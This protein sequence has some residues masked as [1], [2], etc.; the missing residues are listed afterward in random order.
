MRR[1]LIAAAALAALSGVAAAERTPSTDP[2]VADDRPFV[3]GAA[4]HERAKYFLDT[5]PEEEPKKSAVKEARALGRPT[6]SLSRDERELVAQALF[7]TGY[8]AA[9]PDPIALQA[10]LRRVQDDASLAATGWLDE[11]TARRLGLD[12]KQLLPG[13]A[14]A[15]VPGGLSGD[16]HLAEARRVS[17]LA[18]RL[19]TRAVAAGPGEREALLDQAAQADQV[20]LMHR[21]WAAILGTGPAHAEPEE[22]LEARAAETSGG[23]EGG[24]LVSPPPAPPAPGR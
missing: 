16:A 11:D 8:G 17:A 12:P 13:D 18:D 6:A 14:D 4:A 3:P 9:D 19:H 23:R 15:G 7:D 21:E 24:P 20:A 2:R 5:A 10:G 1:T 22:G